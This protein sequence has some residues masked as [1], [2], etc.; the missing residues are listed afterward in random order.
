MPEAQA[1]YLMARVLEHQ[2]QPD[3][4]RLQLQLA[5]QADPAFIPAREFLVELD[6]VTRPTS[7]PAQNPVITVSGTE[8]AP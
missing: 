2:N 7:T 5:L 6:Q 1:R 8:P 3:A 4:S